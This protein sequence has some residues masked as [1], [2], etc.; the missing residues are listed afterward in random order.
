M[1]R[2]LSEGGD[3]NKTHKPNTFAALSAGFTSFDCVERGAGVHALHAVIG[4]LGTNS[5]QV[6]ARS[7]DALD[8][9]R[10]QVEALQACID[11]VA[12]RVA[13]DAAEERSTGGDRLSLASAHL[14]VVSLSDLLV[15]AKGKVRAAQR[16][17]AFRKGGR[18]E[19]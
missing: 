1:P 14:L 9:L 19:R 11:F 15:E 7:A 13:E 17:E 18:Y 10:E 16:L 12:D 8:A 3:M 6:V 4:A 2:Q 5:P